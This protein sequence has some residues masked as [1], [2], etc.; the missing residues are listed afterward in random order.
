MGATAIGTG[1]NSEPEYAEICARELR[2]ISGEEFV[3]APNLI[4]A[5]LIP[6]ACVTYSSEL[7]RFCVQLSKVCNDLTFIVQW[8][9]MRFE[10]NQLAS[11][12]TG[13][14]YHAG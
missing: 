1:I 9:E 7:K 14:F 6:G 11:D 5:T 10:R 8:P 3:L 12:A 4:A 2:I 13:I